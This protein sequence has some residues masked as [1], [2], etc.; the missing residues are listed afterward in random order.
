MRI[1]SVRTALLSGSILVLLAGCVT[2]PPG[3]M[4]D[5]RPGPNKTWDQYRADDQ[6]CQGYAN[7]VV[8]GNVNSDNDREITNTILGA[9]IG[10]G[11]GAAVGNTR[12]AVA[13][14]IIGAILGLSGS[15]PDYSQYSA[16][17]RYDIAYARCMRAKG[18]SVPE[19]G[20]R[21]RYRRGGY[22]AYPPP[23]PPPPGDYGPPPPPP[24]QDEPPPP[25]PGN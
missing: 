5:S 12:G 4:I 1:A 17:R 9:A 19:P 2:P 24:P 21:A 6:A 3:P 11:V 22:G 23:P 14:G 10:T 15:N 8:A 20:W 16:Q 13:G 25:P 18:E 7:D